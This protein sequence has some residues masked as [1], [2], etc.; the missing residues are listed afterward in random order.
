MPRSC[1]VLGVF[2]ALA[3]LCCGLRSVLLAHGRQPVGVNR[4]WLA[5]LAVSASV[6]A[7]IVAGLCGLRVTGN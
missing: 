3:H 2:C 7:A 1:Y 6:S 5:G 4:V